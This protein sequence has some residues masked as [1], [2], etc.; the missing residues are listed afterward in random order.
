MQSG[1]SETL[2][3]KH[4]TLYLKKG[5]FMGRKKAL[6]FQITNF[7]TVYSFLQAG[8]ELNKDWRTVKAM[9]ERNNLEVL[10]V[11]NRFYLTQAQLN[12]LKEEK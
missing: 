3:P 6:K 11:N 12:K 5:D 9:C 4:C 2:S 10:K 1:I 8:K 7:E